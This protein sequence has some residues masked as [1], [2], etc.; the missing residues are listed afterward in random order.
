MAKRIGRDG[1]IALVE[2]DCP[3]YLLIL[4][5]DMRDLDDADHQAALIAARTHAPFTL[6]ELG[7]ATW[8]DELS[9]WEAPPVFGRQG[10]G[11]GAAQTLSYICDQLVP[12]IIERCDLAHDIPTILGGYSLAG[13]F[14]LWSAY[15]TDR[16]AAVVA[17]SPSVWFPGWID[18]ARAQEPRAQSIYLSLG[19]TEEK[20]K[21]PVMAQVGECI[22]TQ[23]ALLERQGVDT[24]LEWNPGNHFK[25]PDIRLSKGFAWCMGA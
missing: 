16:F 17:A 10:F 4:P 13:L 3:E 24:V 20:A 12:G 15:R 23:H 1:R 21:N 9:P 7:I 2:G 8:N 14:A 18:L 6:A 19:T 22:R 5:V 11:S 25:E